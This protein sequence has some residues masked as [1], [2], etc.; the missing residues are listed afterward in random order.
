MRDVRRAAGA[1]LVAV[2]ALVLSGCAQVEATVHEPYP[3]V[4]IVDGAD[5]AAPKTLTLT[6]DAIRRLEVA[7]VVVEDPAALPFA[8]V[9]YDKKGKPWVYTNPTERTFIRVPVT[10]ERITGDTAAVSAGPARGTHV[11]TRA[12]IKLYGAETGVG[13]GH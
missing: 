1:V 13:G 5:K 9:V 12:A 10:I 7:T 8:A 3:A 2:S 6:A 4:E 11:V